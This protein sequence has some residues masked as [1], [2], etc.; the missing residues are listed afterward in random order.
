MSLSAHP[1]APSLG[2]S[3]WAR[4]EAELDAWAAA[5]HTARFWWR[6]DD[7]TEPTAALDRLLALAG[8][9]PLALAVIP[10]RSTGQLARRLGNAG[11]VTVLQHGIA[12]LNL[13]PPGAKKAEL[14]T[15]RTATML[16]NALGTARRRLEALFGPQF[17]PVLVPPWNRIADDLLPLLP[18]AGFVGLST[19]GPRRTIEAA[20]GLR[21]VNTHID[22]VDWHGT[23]RCRPVA[24]LVDETVRALAERR[25]ALAEDRSAEEPL[26][27]DGEPIG[28]LTHHLLDDAGTERFTAD[29]A[30][31]IRQHPSAAWT[32]VREIW[33]P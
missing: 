25:L 12:H 11:N 2:T 9:V 24:D 13:A 10:D 1:V 30:A 27:E 6:D 17:R 7:A 4:L 8:T 18:L 29:L 32:G 28:L 16:A 5:G 31:M 19:A 15:A 22:P 20:P 3:I 23:R 21:Q 26:R 33:P 14:G